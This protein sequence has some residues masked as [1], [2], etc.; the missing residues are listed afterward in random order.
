MELT[1]KHGVDAV[2]EMDIAANAQIAA[3]R[4]AAQAASSFMAPRGEATF[5]GLL[6]VN[7]IRLQFF[8][9]YE[10]DAAERAHTVAAINAALERARSRT[11][12]ATRLQ[13]DDIVA[14]MRRWRRQPR[15]C[16]VTM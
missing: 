10:L 16:V 7:S 8:I 9:V 13:L 3:R 12:C 4:A 5:G 2:I 11:A 15:N 6:L 1:G 14:A